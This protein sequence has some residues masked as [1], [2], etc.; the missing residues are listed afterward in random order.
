MIKASGVPNPRAYTGKYSSLDGQRARSESN[1][2]W[3]IKDLGVLL[4]MMHHLV[5]AWSI[6]PNR[7]QDVVTI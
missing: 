7:I 4:V 2:F 3:N 5:E 1:I 6:L